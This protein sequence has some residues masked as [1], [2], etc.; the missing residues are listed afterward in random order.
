[1][2]HERIVDE[3]GVLLSEL[4]PSD[5]VATGCFA[6]EPEARALADTIE[7]H[8]G[9]RLVVRTL[10]SPATSE[11]WYCAISRAG[12][13]KWAGLQFV[14]GHLGISEATI[15]CVGDEVNDLPMFAG[16]RLSVAMGQARPEVQAAADWITGPVRENGIAEL[17]DRLLG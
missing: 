15:C 5:V 12:V 14:A 8:F 13:S 4:P 11:G 2:L 17:I 7:Q 3:G 1:M 6:P 16:A 9:N 10:P